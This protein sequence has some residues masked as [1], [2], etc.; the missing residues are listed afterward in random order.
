MYTDVTKWDAPCC[1][2]RYKW[3]MS[4]LPV[5]TQQSHL[6]TIHNMLG[7]FAGWHEMKPSKKWELLPCIVYLSPKGHGVTLHRP[8]VYSRTPFNCSYICREYFASFPHEFLFHTC[9]KVQLLLERSPNSIAHMDPIASHNP[10]MNWPPGWFGLLLWSPTGGRQ[11]ITL[12]G[13]VE[14]KQI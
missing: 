11:D 2:I 6:A 3:Y 5:T 4:T 10:S 7:I 13:A 9:Q 1:E 12:A 8:R 14:H